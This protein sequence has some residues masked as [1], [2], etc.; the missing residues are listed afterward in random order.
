MDYKK[1]E[2]IKTLIFD[3]DGVLTNSQL[4]ITEEGD[5]LRSMNTRDGYG[6]KRAIDAG[7]NVIII[8]GGNS[9]GV[10]RRL[11]LLGIKQCHVNI[12]DKFSVLTSIIEENLLNK[13][14]I[15]Y[16]GDDIPDLKCMQ[17]IGIAACP[18][19]AVSEIQEAS[20]YISDYNGGSGCVRDI[21]EKI[22]Q[23]KNL[24]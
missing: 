7:L 11:Q 23:V 17:Y 20:Q 15:M 8:T 4:L 24:W 14:E 3:V 12:K 5:L 19:D 1:L 2:Q 6:L 22:M 13:E 10:E 9:L 16:M 18:A 21:V